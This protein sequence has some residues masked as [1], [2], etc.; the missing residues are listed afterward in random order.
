MYSSGFAKLS[1]F[2]MSN[3]EIFLVKEDQEGIEC[4]ILKRP[5]LEFQDEFIKK[6]RHHQGSGKSEEDKQEECDHV[7]V[8]S[9]QGPVKLGE[10]KVEEENDGF[11]TPTS[12]EHKMPVIKQCP[13]AP[14]KP[15]PTKRKISSTA[16]RKKLLLDL[17]QEVESMFPMPILV[18]LH[19]KI[20]KARREDID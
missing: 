19:Q 2:S 6:Q 9:H 7:R 5:T 20:K 15:K 11:K 12:L 1:H 18:D 8:V 3:S 17:S 16:P 10:F 4:D 14:R 13:P